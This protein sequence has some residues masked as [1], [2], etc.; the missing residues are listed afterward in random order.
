MG[1]AIK[2]CIV[3]SV[4]LTRVGP[5]D[6]VIAGWPC[7]GHTRIG[8]GEDYVTLNFVCFGKCCECYAIFKHIKHML[9]HTF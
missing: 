6:L 4:R 1:F 2:H 8:R 7:Q 5:I 9:L 3:A